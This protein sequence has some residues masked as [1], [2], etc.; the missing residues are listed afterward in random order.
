MVF[1]PADVEGYAWCAEE[2]VALM[3]RVDHAFDPGDLGAVAE[4]VE[5]VTHPYELE[6][7]TRP[8]AARNG[9]PT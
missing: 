6:R 3:R 2:I 7:A 4:V 5:P 9:A 1:D 8:P